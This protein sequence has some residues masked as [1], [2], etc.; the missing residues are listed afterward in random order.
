MMEQT[1]IAIIGLGGIAQLVHLPNIANLSNA[2]VSA[3]AEI[4]KSRLNTIAVK[5]NIEEK[6]SDYNELL[7]K[8]D[9]DAVIIATPTNTHKEIAIASLKANKDILVEKPLARSFEE[10]KEIVDAAQ[11]YN[12]KLMVGMN[13]RFRPDAMILRSLLNSGE[14][15][16]PYYLK[17]GW[18]R[19]QSSTGKWFTQ[20]E[21]SGG[22][23]IIDLG[24]HLLDLSMWL[25]DYQPVESVSTQNYSIQTKNVEDTSISF[26]KLKSNS[27]LTIES[28]W[29]LPLEEDTF[30]L[31]VHGTKGYASLNPFRI[32]KKIE[33]QIIDLIPSQ[34]ESAITIFRKSYINELKSF[35]GAVKNL[36]PVFSSGDEALA[37]MKILEAMYESSNLK[38]EIKL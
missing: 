3:V 10:A 30:Y 28:S 18:I 26:I 23:V 16:E 8:S 13:L 20:K 15:G 4:N 27:L 33:D 35:I 32:Y 34:S 24:I 19:R 11:K 2:V 6:Y 31:N 38:N 9:A 21:E 7:E 17:A 37:R 36:N 22:G 25:L 29:S 1:K 14:I 12:R 5:F